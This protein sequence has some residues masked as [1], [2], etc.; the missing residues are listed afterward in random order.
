MNPMNEAWSLLKQNVATTFTNLPG[1]QMTEIKPHPA[2][3][4]YAQRSGY[5]PDGRVY[6][7]VRDGGKQTDAPL[8]NQPHPLEAVPRAPG[9]HSYGE[10]GQGPLPTATGRTIELQKPPLLTTTRETPNFETLQPLSYDEQTA[11]NQATAR[12]TGKYDRYG[13]KRVLQNDSRN[14]HLEMARNTTPGSRL[15]RFD[16]FSGGKE[17]AQAPIGEKTMNPGIVVQAQGDLDRLD[18]IPATQEEA[19]ALENSRMVSRPAPS[20]QQKLNLRRTMRSG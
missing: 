14:R 9:Q 10:L 11:L 16:P 5:Q 12:R 15:R 8:P 7:N 20:R 19:R 3:V 4:S 17:A 1:G 18:R 2:A 6:P 13:N